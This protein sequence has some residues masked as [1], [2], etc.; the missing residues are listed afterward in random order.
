[1]FRKI[2]KTIKIF[3][4]ISVVL[5][6]LPH[7]ILPLQSSDSQ[8]N[9]LESYLKLNESETRLA[10]FKDDEEA[11]K[12]KL[13]QLEIIN[14]SRKKFRAGQVKLDILASRVANKMCREAAEN[15]FVGHWNLAGEKP[16]HR[17]AFAGGYDHV[18]E[19]AF[20]E[21]SSGNYD[22]SFSNIGSMM[23]SGHEKFMSERAPN[24]GHKKTIIEKSHNFVG[25]GFYL[26]GNQF[27]YYEEFID[28]YLEFENIPVEVKVDEP[29]SI[30]VKTN[31]ES[32]LY[33][34]IIYRENFPKPLTPL[35]LRKKGSYSDFTGEEY[36]SFPAWDLS[37]Y[38]NGIIY[39][40]PLHFPEEGLYYIHI[41]SD[42]KEMKKPLS[43]NTK[44][45]TPESGIVIKVKKK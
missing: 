38:R 40:I 29:C 28:R 20:G 3:L 5:F 1:M 41:Y 19:N 31:G 17:Y 44:G 22:S 14:K 45:K 23:K 6:C 39:T 13:I 34:V 24:D 7:S 21:W 9:D 33:Y 16:Y 42:K 27:R 4:I 36:M 18:S 35:Q 15:D 11:L 12:I 37:R 26:T 2:W 8:T 32:Y 43:L 30:T 25:I 10:E